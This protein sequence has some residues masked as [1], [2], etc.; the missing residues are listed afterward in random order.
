MK[1]HFQYELVEDDDRVRLSSHDGTLAEQHPP[2][3]CIVCK[4]AELAGTLESEPCVVDEHSEMVRSITQIRDWCKRGSLEFVYQGLGGGEAVG[5]EK[6]VAKVRSM[7]PV[8]V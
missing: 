2:G 3:D 4:A 6:A 1:K 5:W 7:L 8:E